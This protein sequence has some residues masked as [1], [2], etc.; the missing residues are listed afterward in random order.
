MAYYHISYNNPQ[1]QFI[2]VRANFE[3]DNRQNTKICLSS[4][5]PGRYEIQN[6]A[7]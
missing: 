3:V 4:W 6:F 2:Q 5:R 1:S 7:V